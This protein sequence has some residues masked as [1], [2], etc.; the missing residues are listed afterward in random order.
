MRRSYLL[1]NSALEY[2]AYTTG[3]E[4]VYVDDLLDNCLQLIDSKLK[5]KHVKLTINPLDNVFANKSE[6]GQI[7]LSI[8]VTFTELLDTYAGPFEIAVSSEQ[9]DGNAR[10][11][12]TLIVN[13]P[14]PSLRE[15]E[16]IWQTKSNYND[17]NLRLFSCSQLTRQNKGKFN[18][19][20]ADES[21]SFHVELPREET[22]KKA[23]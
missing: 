15:L 23:G 1:A 18:I 3:D 20:F 14:D 11:N 7:V 9:T 21:V 16:P 17:V 6:V 12:F 19:V 8:F 22:I 2:S 5:Y 13:K 10:L 4:E